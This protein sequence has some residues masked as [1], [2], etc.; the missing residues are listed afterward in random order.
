M[1]IIVAGGGK[2]GF[3]LARELIAQGP[4]CCSSRRAA[5]AVR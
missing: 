4:K 5:R 3:Y 1:Y 2:V